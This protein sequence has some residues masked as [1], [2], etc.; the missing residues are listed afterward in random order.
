MYIPK[1]FEQENSALIDG[2]RAIEFGALIIFAD[3]RFISS[4]IPFI[5]KQDNG[6]LTLEGHVSRAN[7]LWKFADKCNKA[8]VIFQGPHAYIHPGWYPMKEKTGKVVPTWNYQVIHCQG[9]A[10]SELSESWI[11]DHVTELT[12]FNEK[13]QLNPWHVRDA[14]E[15]YIQ[16]LIKGIVGIKVHVEHM[17]GSL[18][19]NQHHPEENRMGVIEGLSQSQKPSECEVSRI[20]LQLEADR[21]RKG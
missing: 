8:M 3:N 13:G 17:E 5:A 4:H 11:L 9:Y 20:M 15:D 19:M 16:T 18:K 14:P 1:Q 21:N 10:E 2:I 6:I 12:N 7:E